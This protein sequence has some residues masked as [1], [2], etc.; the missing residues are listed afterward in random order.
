MALGK[1]LCCGIGL[2]V[3]LGWLGSV[4]SA[5]PYQKPNQRNQFPWSP[6]QGIQSEG[7]SSSLT[8]NRPQQQTQRQPKQQQQEQHNKGGGGTPEQD[9]CEVARQNR[10][11]CGPDGTTEAQCQEM[12]CCFL[13]GECF[14]GNTVTLH[15]T[16]DAIIVI[17]VSKAVTVPYL[18]LESIGN[19]GGDPNPACA[20]VDSND[21]FI[22]YQYGATECGTR[23]GTGG[24]YL[25]YENRM[26]SGYL[27]DEGPLGS[28][29]RDTRFEVEIQCR[30]SGEEVQA[31]VVRLL[32]Q[33][34]PE[35]PIVP[36]PFEVEMRIASGECTTKGCNNPDDVAYTS[37][38]ESGDYPVYREL[39]ENVYVEVRFLNR[40]DPNIV[41][42]LGRCWA[43]T[44]PDPESVPQWD[45]LVNGCPYTGD[46]HL[47]TLIPST[48]VDFPS[49]YRRFMLKMFT[50]LDPQSFVP[51]QETVFLH[52]EVSVCQAGN[53]CEPTCSANAGPPA[54]GN[55]GGDSS[56]S[57][58]GSDSSPSW[59]GSGSSPSWGGSG[60]QNQ[61]NQQNQ[62]QG[63]TVTSQGIHYRP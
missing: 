60:Q 51:M 26:S 41:L 27:I 8:K 38:Y 59:G 19:V 28:I 2:V 55:T 14:Y 37:Y 46:S 50:F 17:V 32:S 58:G 3:V 45:I 48:N 4:H 53:D 29:T 6:P 16:R 63:T 30:Y 22:I 5:V 7:I 25:I 13:E 12:G 10:V 42:S 33:P 21:A 15:C 61:Q 54:G 23:V 39:K 34:P 57:W 56:P 20:P 44:T 43:T 31:V 24:G 35:S 11:T 49:H 62:R 1:Q 47:T 9:V 36:G 40:N 18:N 52:C